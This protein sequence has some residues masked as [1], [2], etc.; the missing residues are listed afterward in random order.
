MKTYRG[1]KY[2]FIHNSTINR[3]FGQLHVPAAV[4]LGNKP[5]TLG[6]RDCTV[7]RDD[8]AS[9]IFYF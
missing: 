5:Y 7:S 3:I 9:C 1:I 6:I 4:L 8:V 2:S